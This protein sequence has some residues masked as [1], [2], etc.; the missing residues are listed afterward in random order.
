MV[1]SIRTS[2]ESGSLKRRSLARVSKLTG[3]SHVGF[4]NGSTPITFFAK[5]IGAMTSGHEEI[6]TNKP[7]SAHTPVVVIGLILISDHELDDSCSS[8]ML[9]KWKVDDGR[10]I[11]EDSLQ[12][13][14]PPSA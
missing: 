10:T 1:L 13:Y 8:Y 9:A 2:H 12:R 6:G 11:E 7:P 5:V 14:L 3:V 4:N